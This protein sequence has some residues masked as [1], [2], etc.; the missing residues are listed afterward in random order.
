MKK[1]KLLLIAIIGICTSCS[2]DDA[3]VTS[4]DEVNMLNRDQGVS[5]DPDSPETISYTITYSSGKINEFE[6]SIIRYSYFSR[7]SELESYA[8]TE[9][10]N[11]E[12]WYANSDINQIKPSLGGATGDDGDLSSARN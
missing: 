5:L 8:P 11:I 6:K 7:F 12:I 1:V 2:T 3:V 10:N 4:Q 9:V